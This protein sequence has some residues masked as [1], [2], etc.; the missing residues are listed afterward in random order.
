MILKNKIRDE[1]W[2]GLLVGVVLRAS[3][4]SS[5]NTCVS[6]LADHYGNHIYFLL[7]CIQSCDFWWT[8]CFSEYVWSISKRKKQKRNSVHHCH[9]LG[10]LFYFYNFNIIPDNMQKWLDHEIT[11]LLRPSCSGVCILAVCIPAISGFVDDGCILIFYEK[12][13]AYTC[14]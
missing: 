7:Q 12:K 4:I 13:S 2:T 5:L 8:F 6:I 14:N 9:S 10:Y 1:F 11:G 3:T